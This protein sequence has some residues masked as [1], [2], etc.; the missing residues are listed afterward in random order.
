LTS[1][2]TPEIALDFSDI[3]ADSDN[4]GRIYENLNYCSLLLPSFTNPAHQN[5]VSSLAEEIWMLSSN[6][7]RKETKRFP[8]LDQYKHIFNRWGCIKTNL[9]I[10]GGM[11]IHLPVIWGS[12]G[13]QGFDSYPD[14]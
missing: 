13:Y 3:P 8:G 4:S 1:D 14:F 11:N 9:A 10:F 5:I 12:L 6:G 7:T 2:E